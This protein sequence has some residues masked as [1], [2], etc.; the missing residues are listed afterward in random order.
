MRKTSGIGLL[1]LGMALAACSDNTMAPKTEAARPQSVRGGGVTAALSQ[2]DTFRFSITINPHQRTY[3]NLGAGNSIT[4]PAHSLCDVSRS[5]Y[6]IGEWD[7]PCATAQNPQTIQ[8]KAWIDGADHPRVD[9][10]PNVR[11]V[12]SDDPY[13]WVVLT[14]ADYTASIDPWFNIDYCPIITSNICYD[15]SKTDPSVAT[16]HD[17]VTGKVTRRLKHFSGYNVAAGE[18]IDAYNRTTTG[19]F[20]APSGPSHSVTPTVEF[21]GDSPFSEGELLYQQLIR[22]HHRSGYML[23]SG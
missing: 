19:R 8:V 21:N 3:W 11:F 10:Y 6:G 12:P 16:V 23:A 5:S 9:F 22:E 20:M 14:F 13:N 4:F 7:K 1:A 17:P 15:E 18:G 2:T